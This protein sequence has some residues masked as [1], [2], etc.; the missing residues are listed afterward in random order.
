MVDRVGELASGALAGGPQ[1]PLCFVEL[2]CE[3]AVVLKQRGEHVGQQTH[4]GAYRAA[5]HR[6]SW[7]PGLA[8]D[9]MNTSSL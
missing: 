7:I 4:P 2:L 5:G 3:L 8:D 1:A 6:C 9:T